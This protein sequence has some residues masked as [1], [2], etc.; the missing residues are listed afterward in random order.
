MA[1]PGGRMRA[2]GERVERRLS[3][4]QGRAERDG[5]AERAV[6][7]EFDRILEAQTLDYYAARREVL[8]SND[9]RSRC[10]TLAR[11]YAAA[12]VA[13]WL[14]PGPGF[15]YAR[16]FERVCEE[17][18]LDFGEDAGHLEGLGPAALCEALGE[19]LARLLEVRLRPLDGATAERLLKLLYLQ[20]SDELWGE[21][22]DYCQQLMVGVSLAALDLRGAIVECALRCS[23]AYDAFRRDADAEAV[24]RMLRFDAETAFSEEEPAPAVPGDLEL[25]V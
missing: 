3:E 9:F 7:H 19:L 21:H 25:I 12:V 24:K 11:E 2:E 20:A 8:E 10:G 15:D 22:L 23:E 13:R 14:S 4:A 18:R 17:L 16:G 5:A 6:T 1:E